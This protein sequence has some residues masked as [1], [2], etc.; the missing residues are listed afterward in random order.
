VLVDTT[1]CLML[2]VLT[3]GA[4]AFLPCFLVFRH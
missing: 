4:A 2:L 3:V 1:C